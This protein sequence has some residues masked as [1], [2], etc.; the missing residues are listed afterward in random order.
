MATIAE[1]LIF[2]VV[3]RD[4]TQFPITVICQEPEPADP[5]N[6]IYVIAAKPWLCEGHRGE[7]AWDAVFLAL[8]NI[9]TRYTELLAPGELSK[10]EAVKAQQRQ[11][12]WFMCGRQC[13]LDGTPVTA[14]ERRALFDATPHWIEKVRAFLLEKGY[15]SVGHPEGWDARG[16]DWEQP[17]DAIKRLTVEEIQKGIR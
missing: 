2:R 13:H 16:P 12:K 1:T 14:E 4:G 11:C 15:D 9:G 8:Q 17:L 6:L 3:H 5:N 7:T 10:A